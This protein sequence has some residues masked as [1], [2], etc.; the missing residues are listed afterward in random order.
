MP[1]LDNSNKK[2][3]NTIIGA[4]F[5]D[6]SSSSSTGSGGG[7]GIVTSTVEAILCAAASADAENVTLPNLTTL[8]SYTVAVGDVVYLRSQSTV[9]EN[10]L[11]VVGTGNIIAAMVH[12]PEP[13]LYIIQQGTSNGDSLF[14]R[15]SDNGDEIVSVKNGLPTSV[16]ESILFGNATGGWNIS[17]TA[18]CTG[19]TFEVGIVEL[20]PTGVMVSDSAGNNT[21]LITDL[22]MLLTD[23]AN[24]NTN[25]I[26]DSQILLTSAPVAGQTARLRDDE[27]LFTDTVGGDTGQYTNG[28][29][30]IWDI[31]HLSELTNQTFQ[32]SIHAQDLVTNI[33]A[34]TDGY[35]LND[36]ANDDILESD[37]IFNDNNY[38]NWKFLKLNSVQTESMLEISAQLVVLFPTPQSLSEGFRFRFSLDSTAVVDIIGVAP[39]KRIYLGTNI[40]TSEVYSFEIDPYIKMIHIGNYADFYPV[41]NETETGYY[42]Y[43][44]RFQMYLHATAGGPKFPDDII[45]SV[46]KQS[47]TEAL[48]LVEGSYLRHEYIN[49]I[50]NT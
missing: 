16:A 48:T 34:T 14:I 13:L 28:N 9:S 12:T 1:K 38:D 32:M 19:A 37:E 50:N 10:G 26:T 2:S 25:E 29:L 4:M 18:K 7:G 40:L 5:G 33:V 43:E 3:V 36:L 23:I 22:S 24:S 31:L 27:L 45:L 49:N 47:G 17:S 15:V 42:L 21:N 44:I 20:L 35:H 39:V 6:S 46:A 8:D 30:K 11:Y 41:N